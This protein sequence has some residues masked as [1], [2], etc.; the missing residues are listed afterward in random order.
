MVDEG[1]TLEA[2][3]GSTGILHTVGHP[4]WAA[5]E[6]TNLRKVD[7]VF[8]QVIEEGV[9]VGATKVG[10][11]AQASEQTAARQLLKVPLADVL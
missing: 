3:G 10:D 9:E 2:V 4:R 6:H 7:V 11:R 8:L 5:G 1:R